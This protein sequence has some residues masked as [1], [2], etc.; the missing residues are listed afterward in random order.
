VTLLGVERP[1]Y[2]LEALLG[3]ANHEASR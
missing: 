2:V 1:E 3:A